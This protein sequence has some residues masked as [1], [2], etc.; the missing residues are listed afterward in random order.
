MRTLV[1]IA[2]FPLIL[3][4]MASRTDDTERRNILNS[5]LFGDAIQASKGV[6]EIRACGQLHDR[7]QPGPPSTNT[8]CIGLQCRY[9]Y[10]LVQV[11]R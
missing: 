7:C 3:S 11:G 10:C 2:M 5:M 1:V 6:D 8:C 4:L 9:G